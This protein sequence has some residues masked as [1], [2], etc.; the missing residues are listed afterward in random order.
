MCG[1]RT[2]RLPVEAAPRGFT[3]QT[4]RTCFKYL[5]PSYNHIEKADFLYFEVEAPNWINLIMFRDSSVTF[6]AKIRKKYVAF[7]FLVI[8]C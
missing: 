5:S 2:N 8:N 3:N 6:S 1:D 7:F 4:L